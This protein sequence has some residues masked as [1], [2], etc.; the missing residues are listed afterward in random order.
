MEQ[1]R[2]EGEYSYGN[3]KK[4]SVGR[5]GFRDIRNEGFYFVDKTGL[6]KELMNNWGE[7]DIFT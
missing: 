6:I 4:L 7:V 3:H 2:K 5:E 1:E